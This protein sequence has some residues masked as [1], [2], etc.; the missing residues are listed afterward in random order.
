MN[1][2]GLNRILKFEANDAGTTI[3]DVTVEDVIAMLERSAEKVKA[4]A[5]AEL[6]V[7]F[8]HFGKFRHGYSKRVTIG[9]SDYK[10]N[11]WIG[12]DKGR[13]YITPHREKESY[14][15]FDVVND[16]LVYQPKYEDFVQT[17]PKLT[18]GL[19][20]A[21]RAEI[22]EGFTLEES[23]ERE[24]KSL[25]KELASDIASLK[26]DRLP[27]WFSSSEIDLLSLFQK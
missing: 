18:A 17:R 22:N 20:E 27:Y 7:H 16:K 6:E 2:E 24:M 19:I 1:L 3:E 25:D 23:L 15:Y 10:L 8:Q 21:C 5:K 13:I 12:E 11:N 14:G 26:Y 4:Y 9:H